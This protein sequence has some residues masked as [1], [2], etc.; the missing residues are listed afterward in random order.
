MLALVAVG[1]QRR[2]T[3]RDETSIEGGEN[4]SLFSDR[5]NPEG[6]NFKSG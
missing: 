3:S 2:G 1:K 5:V 4:D 6:G